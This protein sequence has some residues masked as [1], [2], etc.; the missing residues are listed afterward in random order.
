MRQSKLF[1]KTRKHAPADEESKNAKLLIKAGFIDK[2][3]A[4][5]YTYL[6][7]GFRVLQKIENIIHDEMEKAGGTEILMPALQPKEN[8]VKPISSFVLA[9]CDEA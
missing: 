6:P 1:T 5:V 3:Q 7:L 4:G 2:L 8:W 9:N